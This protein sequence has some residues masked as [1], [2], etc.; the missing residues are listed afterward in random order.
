MEDIRP[1]VASSPAPILRPGVLPGVTLLSACYRAQ[2]F[3]RHT[4]DG[5]ALGVIEAGALG[6][7][8]RGA[9]VV[10]P[11]GAV[12]LVVP[13]E[14]HDGHAAAAGGWRY[15]MFYF[16]P[17][18]FCE[19][20]AQ[21]ADGPR[22]LPWFSSGVLRDDA[23]AA[24]VLETH[25]CLSD[26]ETSLLERQSRLLAL[27]TTFIRRHADDRPPEKTVGQ[28]IGP[29]ARVRDAIHARCGEVVSLDELARV[30]GLS[31][32]HL[33]RAFYRAFGLTPHAYLIQTRVSAARRRIE[34]GMPLS[35]AALES[36]FCDQSHL[37][38]H[39]RRIVGLSP[40]Q[41]RNFVQ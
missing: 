14:P 33:I 24:M 27:V 13:G 12:N 26:P 11:A 5:Y 8:Y 15:R 9:H 20:A 41:Y 30:S 6:F 25:G 3:S 19:A 36:G 39:F 17:D 4:H 31:P 40:G 22:D 18:V 7:D 32:Y 35:A 28:E 2:R 1:I 38:R 23:L 10:A 37:N 34:A 16:T 21:M 29:L